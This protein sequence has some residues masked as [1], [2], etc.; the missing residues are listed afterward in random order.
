MLKSYGINQFPD[1][2]SC[3]AFFESVFWPDGPICPHCHGDQA[4]KLRN[5]KTKE[6]LERVEDVPDS[7]KDLLRLSRSNLELFTAVQKRLIATL[8]EQPLIRER[9]ARLLSIPGVGEITALT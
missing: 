3:R 9:V 6:L 2:E 1:E 4:W 8:R 5:P 7:V